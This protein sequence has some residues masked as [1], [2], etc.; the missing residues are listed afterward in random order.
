MNYYAI[1]QIPMNA[2]KETT[3]RA[4]RTLARRY[5][6]DAGPGSSPEK[7][8]Q[9][10]EAYEVLSDPARRAAYDSS[11]RPQY[12]PQTPVEPLR[13][14][15]TRAQWGPRRGAGAAMFAREGDLIEEL[16]DELF[17]SAF[18]DFFLSRPFIRW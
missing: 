13:P 3:R 7:F 12:V 16:F 10:V 11:L 1:L 2:D 8:R 4:F 14:E 9:I 6:P 15:P 18:D 17:R 5:H